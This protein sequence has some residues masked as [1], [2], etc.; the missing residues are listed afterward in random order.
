MQPGLWHDFK[1]EVEPSRIRVW[2]NHQLLFDQ[3]TSPLEINSL[4]VTG[5]KAIETGEIIVKVVNASQLPQRVKLTL[6][7][8]IESAPSGKAWILSSANRW[9]ENSLEFPDRVRPIECPIADLL[10]EGEL[11]EFAPHSLTVMRIN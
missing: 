2:L 7:G 3:S 4:H 10:I 11:F 8:N 9:D 6:A 5:G 1:M